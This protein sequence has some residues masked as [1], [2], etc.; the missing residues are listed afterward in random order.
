M[1]FAPVISLLHNP[2]YVNSALTRLAEPGVGS[3]FGSRGATDHKWEGT[4][5]LCAPL[6]LSDFKQ[7]TVDE[8]V[9]I[10]SMRPGPL[11]LRP[12]NPSPGGY[13]SPNQPHVPPLPDPGSAPW[14]GTSR[15]PFSHH[16]CRRPVR[17]LSPAQLRGSVP[18]SGLLP[19]S[20]P[21]SPPSPPGPSPAVLP[22][23][24]PSPAPS[25]GSPWPH[26]RPYPGSPGPWLRPYSSRR[27][28]L[29]ASLVDAVVYR[30]LLSS[31]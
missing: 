25:P 8:G 22:R 6:G 19:G 3:M 16:G 20:D 1:C 30:V 24:S 17:L 5:A 4:L 10:L 27:G 12:G 18:G 29:C 2:H 13:G 26:P 28:S 15:H 9:G 14:S 11:W 31:P 21:G 23:A 7:F